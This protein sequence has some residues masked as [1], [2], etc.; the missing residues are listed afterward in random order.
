M[1]HLVGQQWYTVRADTTRFVEA[2][3]SVSFALVM[4]I[5]A[6]AAAAAWRHANWF[7]TQP[8]YRRW[9]HT[10]VGHR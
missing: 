5:A 2:M 8:W 4:V 1:G 7:A 9:W 6:R 10:M 3:D